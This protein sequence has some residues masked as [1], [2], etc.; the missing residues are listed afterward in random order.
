M[1]RVTGGI[2]QSLA[3]LQ[4]NLVFCLADKGELVRGMKTGEQ[5]SLR[6]EVRVYVP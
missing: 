6:V 4:R 3:C 2:D 1:K 5:P